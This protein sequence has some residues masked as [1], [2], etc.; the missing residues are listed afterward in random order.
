MSKNPITNL[1]KFVRQV[2]SEAFNRPDDLETQ[3]KDFANSNNLPHKEAFIEWV[4]DGNVVSVQGGFATQDAMYKNRLRS[5]ADLYN[6]F[7]KEF[8]S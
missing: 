6:Y 1:R 2:I 7:Q 3:A 5:M 8:L 4:N